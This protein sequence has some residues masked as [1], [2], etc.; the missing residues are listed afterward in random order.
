LTFR[1]DL[2]VEGG[3][4]LCV[5]EV[6]IE[7]SGIAGAP[8]LPLIASRLMR[9]YDTLHAPLR[10]HFA[11][12]SADEF[13]VPRQPEKL[14]SERV[15][16]ALGALR[17]LGGDAEISDRLGEL[18]RAAPEADVRRI[19]PLE[20]AR[21][22]RRKPREMVEACLL[23]VSGGLLGM[24]W[25]LLCPR[26]RGAKVTASRLKDLP[27]E[28][29]PREGHCP[30]CNVTY[31]RNFSDNV[32]LTFHPAKAIRPMDE[33]EFCLFGPRSTPHVQVQQRV[34]PGETRRVSVDLADGGYRVRMLYG[35]EPLDVECRDLRLPAV[36]FSE[37]GP[38]AGPLGTPGVVEI[39]NGTSGFV[40]AVVEARGWVEDALTARRATTLQ[41]FRDLFGSDV[42]NHDD[43]ASVEQIT[44]M[45]TDLRGSTALY[46]EIGEA[47]AYRFVRAHFDYLAERVRRNDG[48]IVKTIGDAVMAA[49]ADPVD[50]LHAAIEIQADGAE[51]NRM[52]D[53]GGD[54][55]IAVKLGMHQGPAFAVTLNDRLDYFGTTAN[56]AARLSDLSEGGD[57]VMSQEMAADAAIEGVLAGHHVTPSAERVKGFVE[58]VQFVRIRPGT[59]L[60][61]ALPKM[62]ECAA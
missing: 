18:V 44:L 26:C 6:E 55:R 8:L 9:A 21:R 58:P 16:A 13:A 43:E 54:R 49:F 37:A 32:E 62:K 10:A 45:F 3:G 25:D 19:R 23:S 56:K 7:A 36:T 50:A 20:L 33:G 14:V 29:H 59:E 40:V 28:G 60:R 30:S 2:S 57:I 11:T 15:D 12:Q 38:E 17:E 42:L 31:D 53:G 35:G 47:T 4:T 24:Q 22:W 61:G 34:L 41:Y 46:S 27:R 1:L 39:T 5:Y 51:L 48:A 52:M